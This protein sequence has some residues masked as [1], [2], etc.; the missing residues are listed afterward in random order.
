MNCVY[1][2]EGMSDLSKLDSGTL[3]QTYSKWVK[4]YG[5][6][7][8]W[9]FQIPLPEDS[10]GIVHSCHGM[11]NPASQSLRHIAAG[12]LALGRSQQV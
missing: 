4:I 5:E 11:L 6:E 2:K 8:W 12:C 7:H 3:Q 9:T 1:I 10:N